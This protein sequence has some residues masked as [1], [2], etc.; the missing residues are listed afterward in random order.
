MSSIPNLGFG[1]F[2]LKGDAAY[3]AVSSALKA[4][5]RHIDTAQAYDNEAEVGRAIADSG[6][7]REELF[8]T[9]K[10]WMSNYDDAHFLDSVRDS[11]KKLQ[12]DAV[13]LLLLHWPDES[14]RVEMATYLTLLKEAKD[15]G[16]T[17]MIGV[18]NF[19]NAQLDQAVSILGAGEIATNQVEIHPFLQNRKVIEKARQHRIRLTGYMPLAVGKVMEDDTLRSIAETHGV[20]PA[21][22]ALAW[23]LQQGFVTIPS[24][25]NPAHIESNLNARELT[26]SDEEMA[27]IAKL[28]R[29]ERIA[30]PEFAPDWD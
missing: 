12:L 16:L 28:D 7:A 25:T 19:T 21:D 23:Q 15:Q 6:I 1:T 29:G 3:E 18:S 4:G 8:V 9:T 24:S 30:N 13:D 14:G 22:I 20:S 26:L 10:V 17:R 2:R 27:A 11:L 5:F